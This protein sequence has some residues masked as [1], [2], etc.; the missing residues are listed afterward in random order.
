MD[1]SDMMGESIKSEADYLEAKAGLGDF[2]IFSNG[3]K[4]LKTQMKT[5][6]GLELMD[7]VIEQMAPLDLMLTVLDAKVKEFEMA[8]PTFKE[9]KAVYG[10]KATTIFEVKTNGDETEKIKITGAKAKKFWEEMEAN[11]GAEQE[12]MAAW[13]G[14]ALDI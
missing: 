9:F 8:N 11:V 7:G 6:E 13:C 3:L 1:I 12:C 2:L 14:L 10:T 4:A 5:K